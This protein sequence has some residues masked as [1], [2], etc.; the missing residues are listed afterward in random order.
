MKKVILFVIGCLFLFSGCAATDFIS[1][2]IENGRDALVDDLIA[3]KTTEEREEVY[4]MEEIEEGIAYIPVQYLFYHWYEN[5]CDF[6]NGKAY[7]ILI[8]NKEINNNSKKYMLNLLYLNQNEFS[9]YV[10]N[11][12]YSITYSGTYEIKNS[13][14]IF[15]YIYYKQDD[16]INSIWN[17]NIYDEYTDRTRRRIQSV[18]IDANEMKYMLE[19]NIRHIFCGD[20]FSYLPWDYFLNSKNEWKN[21]YLSDSD[22]KVYIKENYI[23]AEQRGYSFQSI[24]SKDEFTLQFDDTGLAEHCEPLTGEPISDPWTASITFNKDNTWKITEKSPFAPITWKDS[25]GNW[26]LFDNH[27]LL[28]CPSEKMGYSEHEYCIFYLDFYEE[29]VYIPCYVKCDDLL[30]LYK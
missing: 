25:M 6:L 19:A 14:L 21:N 23:V 3:G 7:K 4:T 17:V 9:Q 29:K 18:M 13:S 10:P 30:Y 20:K 12:N 22:S 5:K 11:S 1:D 24:N 27:I 2:K 15:N 8:N 26:K 16:D 28:L